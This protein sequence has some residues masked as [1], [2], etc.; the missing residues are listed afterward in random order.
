MKIDYF[1]GIG[2]GKKAKQ[3]LENV[4]GSVR[5][6]VAPNYLQCKTE[7]DCEDIGISN[8]KNK[9]RYEI[10]FAESQAAPALIRAYINGGIKKPRQIVLI[11][12]LGLNPSSL[13]KSPTDQMHELLRRSMEFW[14]SSNQSLAISGN[15]WTFLHILSQT[16]PY[17]WR[18]RKI[19]K[20]AASQDIREDVMRIAKEKN[21][22]IYASSFDTLFPYKEII[23]ENPELSQFIHEIP[24]THLNR[25]TPLGEDQLQ[26]IIKLSKF[27]R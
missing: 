18:V 3:R 19:Y 27:T 21:L 2:Q 24:G 20:Y 1:L 12:P 25:P 4:F 11:Q 22:S 7:K 5:F 13:G 9:L 10:V 14:R 23:N 15:R 8:V 26:R 16:V 6:H 17:L